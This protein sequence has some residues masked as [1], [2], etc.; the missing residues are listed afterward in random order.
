ME[1]DG[2]IFVTHRGGMMFVK[3]AIML[4]ILV[5]GFGTAVLFLWNWLMPSLFGLHAITFWQ[6][7]GLLGLSWILF[8]GPKFGGRGWGPGGR[9]MHRR[10]ANMTPEQREQF[11]RGMQARCGGGASPTEPAPGA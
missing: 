8:R 2:K 10:W 5:P 1:R 3:V 11:R 4:L 6:A 7:L 9:G